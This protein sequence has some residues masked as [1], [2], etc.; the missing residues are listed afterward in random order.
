MQPRL[1]AGAVPSC[2]L[3]PLLAACGLDSQQA[4]QVQLSVV[5]DGSGMGAF[6]ND[7][8]YHIE[9]TTMRV[10]FDNVEF[11]TG[12]EMHASLLHRV[13]GALQELVIPTAYAHPG[14]YAGGEIAGEMDGRFVV[15][16]LADG[17]EVGTATM[18]ATRYNGANFVF[19]RATA[20]DVPAGDPLLGHTMQL[21]G[22][23][24]R[25][26]ATWSFHGFIDEEEGKRVIGLPI[27]DD[28]EAGAET[29]HFDVD[30]DT[31]VALGLQMLMVDPFEPDTAFD[32]LD[33]AELDGDGD[34]DV[35]LVV[36]EAANNLILRQLQVH[37][38]YAVS[39]R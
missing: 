31:D 37:D 15:D 28:L 13:G 18:L 3:I 12:G 20:N 10:A 33:F 16:W 27:G 25:D 9:I 7:L 1:L 19:T 8:G 29:P 23:A 32:K 38:Q 34:G 5:V 35:E 6:D 36:G 17:T 24:T 30:G 2:L 39:I 26:G 4:P 22:T 11:T 21:A 14:H